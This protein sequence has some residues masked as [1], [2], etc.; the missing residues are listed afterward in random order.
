MNDKLY[1]DYINYYETESVDITS[2]INN[3]MKYFAEDVYKSIHEKSL[4]FD[5]EQD[6]HNNN[7]LKDLIHG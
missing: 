3:S 5:F 4:N 7:I 2:E 1:N 6:K